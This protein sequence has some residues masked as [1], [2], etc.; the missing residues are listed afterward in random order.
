MQNWGIAEKVFAIVTD[1]ASNMVSAVHQLKVRHISCFAHTLNLVVMDTLKEMH[2]LT[3]LRRK[4]RGIVTHFHSSVK[5]SEELENAQRLQTSS[6]TSPEPLKLII[7][8]ETR[9]NSTFYM[10]EQYL[11]LHTALCVVQ[12]HDVCHWR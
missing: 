12:R 10:F 6:S 7:E 5:S 4:V 8:V 1:N 9:W 11:H 3:E 2:Q